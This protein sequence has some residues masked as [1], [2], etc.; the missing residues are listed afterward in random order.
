MKRSLI[1]FAAI[2]SLA[3]VAFAAATQI[4]YVDIRPDRSDDCKYNSW[5]GINFSVRTDDGMIHHREHAACGYTL[6]RSFSEKGV[7]CRIDS[8]MC[9]D[10]SYYGGRGEIEVECRLDNGGHWR[11]ETAQIECPES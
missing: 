2:V 10:H 4:Y 3:T 8:N 9:G 5:I 11:T 7:E 1:A 6:R